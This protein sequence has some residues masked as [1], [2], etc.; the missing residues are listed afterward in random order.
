[1]DEA[2]GADGRGDPVV[3]AGHPHQRGGL[4]FS[5]DGDGGASAERQGG[6]AVLDGLVAVGVAGVGGDAE[7]GVEPV[8]GVLVRG[9]GRG[10]G[11]SMGAAGL[12][13]VG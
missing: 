12:W 1:V 8:E 7:V 5:G 10:L 3:L 4:V 9:G 6:L 2:G 11:E 13:V